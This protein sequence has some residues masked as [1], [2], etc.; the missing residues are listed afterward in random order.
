MMLDLDIWQVTFL[1]VALMAAGVCGY[2]LAI[3][4]RPRR[5]PVVSASAPPASGASSRDELLVRGLIGANDVCSDQALNAHVEQTLL[6]AGVRK[7]TVEEGTAFDPAVHDAKSTVPN[8]DPA[9]AHLVAQTIR[10][11][12]QHDDLVLRPP[13]VAVWVLRDGKPATGQPP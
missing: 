10:P 12:W 2:S 5:T 1:A 7:V 8:D 13:E 3:A 9:K 4:R 11:G 6:R